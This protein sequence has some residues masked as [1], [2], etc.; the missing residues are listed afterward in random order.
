[1]KVFYNKELVDNQNLKHFMQSLTD[2]ISKRNEG[3]SVV[4]I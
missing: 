2:G 3:Y 1:M 4:V